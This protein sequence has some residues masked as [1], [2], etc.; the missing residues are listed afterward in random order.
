MIKGKSDLLELNSLQNRFIRIAFNEVR[1]A[2]GLTNGKSDMSTFEGLFLGSYTG[3]RNLNTQYID[4]ESK[5]GNFDSKTGIWTGQVGK[6]AYGGADLG[7]GYVGFSAERNSIISFTMP[8][9]FGGLEWISKN[10]GRDSPFYNI[11]K[12]YFT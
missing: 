8:V 11:I 2:F 10:K 6:I 5:W 1:P 7:I 9:G 12:E 3:K 4:M